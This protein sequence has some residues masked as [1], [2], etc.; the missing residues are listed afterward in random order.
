MYAFG[1]VFRVGNQPVN[2]SAA[3]YYN[4]VKPDFGADWQARFQIQFL[5]PK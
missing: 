5:L 3:T 2:V 4:A 1:K